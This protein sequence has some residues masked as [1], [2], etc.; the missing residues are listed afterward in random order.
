MTRLD[1]LTVQLIADSITADELG[2]LERILRD[3]PS[4]AAAFVALLDLDAALWGRKGRVDLAGPVMQRVEALLRQRLS[5]GVMARIARLPQPPLRRRVRPWRWSASLALVAAS[6]ML[7]VGAWLWL[8]RPT[9]EIGAR[10]VS[11][12][13]DVEIV[14]PSGEIQAAQVGQAVPPGSTLRTRGGDSS[15]AITW[16]DGT[17]DLSPETSVRLPEAG[18]RTLWLDQ[19]VLRGAQEQPAA[20]QP[21]VVATPLA[22]MRIE[23][24]RFHIASAGHDTLRLDMETGKAEV[25]RQGDQKNLAIESG[26][27][28]FVR[29]EPN[30]LVTER[31]NLVTAPRRVLGFEGACALAFTADGEIVAASY[32]EIRRF[33]PGS[34]VQKV[35]LA[36]NGSH[37]RWGAFA[38]D[39]KTLM[40][41]R[42]LQNDDPVIFW[43]VPA[44]Q[45]KRTIPARI[46]DRQYFTLAPDASWLASVDR[47]ASHRTLH[48]WDVATGQERRTVTVPKNIDC[49]AAAPVGN[50]LA[51]GLADLSV[52]ERS[53]ILLLDPLTGEERGQLPTRA[54]PAVL[55]FAA[56][57]RHLAVGI[58]GQVQIWDLE[59]R[60][61]LRTIQGFERK[62]E[63]LTFSPDG[64]LVAGGTGDG[65]VWLWNVQ[66]GEPVQVIQAGTRGVRLL[67]FTPD[68]RALL[69]GRIPHTPLM[70]WDVPKPGA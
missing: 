4:A 27:S 35:Q 14:L 68:G 57:G 55:A 44:R 52:R 16:I 22:E 40:V 8:G 45:Q 63:A 32:R 70:L 49:L 31:A 47:Q 41:C 18:Q 26:D 34:A 54:C 28:V 30:E 19:G 65:Q 21:L 53:Y 60:E 50:L 62:L 10:V 43:D 3:D 37:G 36:T 51:V 38:N 66:R 11:V 12:Q 15:A 6:V 29:A 25:I 48:L 58:T 33:G 59:K 69:T 24:E 13:G 20:R 46:A 17:L 5:D 9:E 67:A 64:N 42:S 39:G 2:E 1:E 7:M 23:G 61:L 56:D